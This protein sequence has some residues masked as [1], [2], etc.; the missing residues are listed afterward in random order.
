MCVTT[1]IGLLRFCAIAFPPTKNFFRGMLTL[2]NISN[3]NYSLIACNI[4]DD[5]E[6]L[7]NGLRGR[8]T[9]TREEGLSGNE[10]WEFQLLGVPA[11][12]R[13]SYLLNSQ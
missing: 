13:H 9:L 8:L 12:V 10:T 4:D 5:N 3:D 2:Q 7:P 11:F 6:L 1:S